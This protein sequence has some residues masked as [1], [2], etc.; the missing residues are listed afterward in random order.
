MKMKMKNDMCSPDWGNLD[1]D[2][3]LGV[4]EIIRKIK[5]GARISGGRTLSTFSLNGDPDNRYLDILIKKGL[6]RYYR[7]R[8]ENWITMVGPTVEILDDAKFIDFGRLLLGKNDNED[9]LESVTFSNGNILYCDKEIIVTKQTKTRKLL[10]F[11]W[12]NRK[13]IGSSLARKGLPQPIDTLSETTNLDK[14]TI[15]TTV[16]KWRIKLKAYNIPATFPDSRDNQGYLL[17]IDNRD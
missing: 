17:V 13:I 16:K 15:R 10:Y 14:K 3:T 4:K 9:E 8:A 12:K 5:D 6:I 1:S 2:D 7:E 11:L